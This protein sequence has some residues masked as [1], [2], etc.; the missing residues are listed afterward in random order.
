MLVAR[1][2]KSMAIHRAKATAF[3][4][5]IGFKGAP[6]HVDD[7]Y[8]LDVDDIFEIEDILPE[9]IKETYS[10]VLSPTENSTE[11]EVNLGYFILER[12]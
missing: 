11:D 12:L 9:H 4:K 2:N 6:L 7:K 1:E 5:H 8:G 3:Y 10:I